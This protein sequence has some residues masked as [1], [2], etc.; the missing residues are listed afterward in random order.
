MNRFLPLIVLLGTL[1]VPAG[2]SSAQQ[3]PLPKAE[4]TLDIRYSEAADLFSLMDNV[5]NWWEGFTNPVR[6]SRGVGEAVRL[7]RRRSDLGAPL[8]RIPTPDFLRPIA[9]HG[10]RDLA[11]RAIRL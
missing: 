9:G 11:A 1:V 2:L 7:V 4:I 5:A 3:E 10:R 8:R 6:L